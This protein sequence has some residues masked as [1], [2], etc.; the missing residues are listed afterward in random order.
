M[1]LADARDRGSHRVA[2]FELGRGEVVGIGRVDASRERAPGHEHPPG[3]GGAKAHVGVEGVEAAHPEPQVRRDG[4]RLEWGAGGDHDV[5]VAAR[6]DDDARLHDLASALRF[7]HDRVDVTVGCVRV[8]APRMQTEPRAG[9]AQ[10]VERDIA[11]RLGIERHGVADD[12]GRSA[13]DQ[14]PAPPALDRGGIGRTPLARFGG[15]RVAAP[16]ET[17]DDLLAQP[18]DHLGAAAVVE[19]EQQVDQAERREPADESVPL[20][21]QHVGAAASRGHRGGD[22]RAAGSDDEHVGPPDDL[23]VARRLPPRRRHR[24]SRYRR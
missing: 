13:P 16:S 15:A 18:G 3:R 14:S 20:D 22:A 10:E 1:R 2:T 9:R 24:R 17:V 19:R 4:D 23:E 11:E 8:R 12:V 21:Q 5:A 6:V 7:E